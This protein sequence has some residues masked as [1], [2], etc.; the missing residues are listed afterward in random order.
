MDRLN[1]AFAEQPA[2]EECIT[3]TKAGG[4]DI[5][6]DIERALQCKYCDPGTIDANTAPKNDPNPKEDYNDCKR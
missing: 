6:S 3:T 4:L 2:S 1:D 5:I